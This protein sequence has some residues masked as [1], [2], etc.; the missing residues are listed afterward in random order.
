MRDIVLFFRRQ[1]IRVVGSVQIFLRREGV[2]MFSGVIRCYL[3]C[4]LVR[5][6]AVQRCGEVV[7]TARCRDG[8]CR[9]G[10]LLSSFFCAPA[11]GASSA[12][13]FDKYVEQPGR[14]ELP[15]YWSA[16]DKFKKWLVWICRAWGIAWA[17]S[18][19]NIM[20]A[21]ICAGMWCRV[22]A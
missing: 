2:K 19:S 3:M 9:Q 13:I 10:I 11:S 7:L 8:G 5:P 18:H 20:M 4:R 6:A 15:K 21:G 16:L 1:I 17:L 14:A 12:L 22:L